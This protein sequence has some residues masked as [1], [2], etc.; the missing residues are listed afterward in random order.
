MHSLL[1]VFSVSTHVVQEFNK[2]LSGVALMHNNLLQLIK[3]YK[4]TRTFKRP[5]YIAFISHNYVATPVCELKF[6]STSR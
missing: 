3:N 6:E 4:K 2:N 1:I 5:T